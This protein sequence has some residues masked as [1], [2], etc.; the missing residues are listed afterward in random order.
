ML[1]TLAWIGTYAAVGLIG[2]MIGV[3]IEKKRIGGI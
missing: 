1:E 3:A 2:I